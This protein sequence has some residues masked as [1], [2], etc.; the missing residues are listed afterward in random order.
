MWWIALKSLKQ[1]QH[2]E[3]EKLRI[4]ELEL[5]LKYG[6]EPLHQEIALLKKE[7]EYLND[8]LFETKRKA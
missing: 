2:I 3:L 8:L 1:K 6:R 4:K 5:N 7:I